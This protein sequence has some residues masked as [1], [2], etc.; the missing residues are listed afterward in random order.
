M[1]KLI[2]NFCHRMCLWHDRWRNF[3]SNGFLAGTAEK[4]HFLP[5][6]SER[7]TKQ[8][9]F[10]LSCFAKSSD[11]NNSFILFDS[12]RL[13]FTCT[14]DSWHVRV[15]AMGFLRAQ[16]LSIGTQTNIYNEPPTTCTLIHVNGCARFFACA[17]FAATVSFDHIGF[18]NDKA[19]TEQ[20][21][22]RCRISH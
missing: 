20:M 13:F 15:L 9:F 4:V 8:F 12:C 3:W 17:S 14:L 16:K 22:E 21:R 19:E 18:W 6:M 5:E 1:V 7:E 11:H 2:R 10:F